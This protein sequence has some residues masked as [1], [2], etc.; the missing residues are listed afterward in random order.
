[1]DEATLIFGLVALSASA[2]SAALGYAYMPKDQKKKMMKPPGPNYVPVYTPEEIVNS[3]C[4]GTEY[5]MKKACHNPET[6]EM[7]DGLQGRCGAGKEEWILDPAAEG[8]EPASGSG[9]CLSDFRNCTVDCPTPCSGGTWKY[10]PADSCKV[11]TYDDQ[12]PPQQVSTILDGVT[13]CGKGVRNQILDTTENNF[14]EAKGAGM[15]TKTKV[16]S[17][18]VGCPAGVQETDGCAY[19]SNRQKSANGCMKKDA[20]GNA[21]EYKADGTN[22]VGCGENGLQEYFYNPIDASTCGRLSDWEPCSGPPCPVDCQGDW[23]QASSSNPEGWEECV[24]A[25]DTQPQQKRVYKVTRDAQYGGKQCKVDDEVVYN[26]TTQYRNCGSIVP[27]CEVGAWEGDETDCQANGFYKLTR[28]LKENRDGAC[29][30]YSGEDELSCCY[31]GDDWTTVGKCGEYKRYKQKYVQTTANCKDPSVGVD[32]KDCNEAID[33]VGK[34]TPKTK[35]ETQCGEIECGRDG[36]LLKGK[37]SKTSTWEEYE[38]TTAAKYGG[39]ACPN[40]AGDRRN[41]VFGTWSPLKCNTNVEKCESDNRLEC[42]DKNRDC[43][44]WSKQG[45]CQ[46]SQY[47]RWMRENCPR[48][49]GTEP[50]CRISDAGDCYQA[51]NWRNEGSCS[52][53]GRHV[54]KQYQ[55]TKNCPVGTE[56]RELPCCTWNECKDWSWD[57]D[58]CYYDRRS[59]IPNMYWDNGMSSYELKGGCENFEMRAYDGANYT[60]EYFVMQP[61]GRKDVPDGWNDRVGSVYAVPKWD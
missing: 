40:K 41:E 53:D 44:Y 22:N 29:S 33:C 26:G 39:K 32:W 60:G 14:V 15:C 54:Q 17:C 47:A 7:L 52:Q 55:D 28:S 36:G 2:G 46:G 19:Y 11:I 34:W 30:A 24:G 59:S 38:I 49:C 56:T 16:G 43:L 5:I 27:C 13:K 25:C 10:D 31:Q 1:M 21:L 3:D 35:T 18:T 23:R 57:G 61:G 58:P 12:N 4:K 51:K 6:G 48:S 42:V 9:T 37:Q 50:S 8:F 20:N 45:F